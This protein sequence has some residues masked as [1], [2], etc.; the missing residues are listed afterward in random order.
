MQIY[1]ENT[2]AGMFRPVIPSSK[3]FQKTQLLL[4]LLDDLG[5]FLQKYAAQF[6]L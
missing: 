1:F 3:E 6:F 4:Q 5:L 2:S